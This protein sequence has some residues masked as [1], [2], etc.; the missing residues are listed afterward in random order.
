MTTVCDHLIFAGPTVFGGG[1]IHGG[2]EGGRRVGGRVGEY[3]REEVGYQIGMWANSLGFMLS[4]LLFVSSI[5]F[6]AL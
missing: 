5:S 2:R 4:M 1:G 6:P 3:Q